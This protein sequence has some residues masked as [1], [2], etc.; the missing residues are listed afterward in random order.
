MWCGVY[1]CFTGFG[2]WMDEY[3]GLMGDGWMD[4]KVKVSLCFNWAPSHEGVL[5]ELRY[6]STFLTSA[7]GEDEWSASPP[8]HYTHQGKSPCY[9]LDRWLGG[10]QSRSGRGGEENNSQPLPGLE[11]PIIQPVAQRYTT[12]PSLLPLHFSMQTILCTVYV[13]WRTRTNT[14]C[15]VISVLL[16]VSVN[17]RM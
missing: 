10:P 2:C 6:S 4:G 11:L 13:Y 17:S 8:S 3:L 14:L 15:S 1:M 16:I 7:L 5:G 12:E 9:S